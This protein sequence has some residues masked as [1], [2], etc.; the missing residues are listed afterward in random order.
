LS[1][2][3]HLGRGLLLAFFFVCSHTHFIQCGSRLLSLLWSA[4]FASLLGEH[5]AL[6]PSLPISPPTNHPP[7]HREGNAHKCFFL[8]CFFPWLS[9]RSIR[10]WQKPIALSLC[11][12]LSHSLCLVCCAPPSLPCGATVRPLPN[13]RDREKAQ[14]VRF[15]PPL[16]PPLSPH[17]THPFRPRIPGMQQ[18]L[19]GI[20]L[21]VLLLP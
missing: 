8:L 14:K 18:G 10:G 11:L 21:Y 9:S 15:C 4:S 3:F 17:H 12:S 19:R 16:S 20:D 2:S 5:W 1:E 13:G 7:T 6:P